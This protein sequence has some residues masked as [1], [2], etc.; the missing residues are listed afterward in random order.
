MLLLQR[1]IH[2]QRRKEKQKLQTRS[3]RCQV[4]CIR[5]FINI[6]V[7]AIL[8]AAGYLIFYMANES[9]RVSVFLV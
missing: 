1:D 7:I 9:I 3:K 5:V 6:V 8:G 4:I 2:I